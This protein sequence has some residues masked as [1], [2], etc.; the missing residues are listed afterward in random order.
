MSICCVALLALGGSR[1]G[2]SPIPFGA[3]RAHEASW[4]HERHFIEFRARDGLTGFGHGYIVYGRLDARGEVI[5]SH[6][7]GYSDGDNGAIHIYMPHAAIGPLQKYFTHVPTA[8]YR[9]ILTT[10]QYRAL[11]TKIADM[12]RARPPFHMLFLNC[13]DFLGEIAESIGLHR[14]PIPMVPTP[15]VRWL[16]AFNGS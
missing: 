14:P 11:N 15:Y 16:R 10:E 8:V 13:T 3:D 9:R 1:A 4:G 6:L 5:E 2:A 12:R 7:V